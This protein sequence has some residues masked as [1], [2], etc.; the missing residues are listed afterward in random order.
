MLCR[1]WIIPRSLLLCISQ[2][3]AL[4]PFA[5][6]HLACPA[7]KAVPNSASLGTAIERDINDDEI[8]QSREVTSGC[9]ALVGCIGQTSS[10]IF[11]CT[12]CE[13]AVGVVD[14]VC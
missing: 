5:V 9:A 7:P 13:H 14:R 10:V 8:V 1:R 11:R 2:H 4:F 3:L 12:L 6:S